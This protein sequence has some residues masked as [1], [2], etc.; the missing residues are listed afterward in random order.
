MQLRIEEEDPTKTSIPRHMLWIEARRNKDG[1]MTDSST[2][3]VYDKIVSMISLFN[4]F[5]L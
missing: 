3:E 1:V 4:L 5:I 2:I